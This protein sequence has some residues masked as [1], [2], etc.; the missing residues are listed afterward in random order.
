M[1]EEGWKAPHPGEVDTIRQF[2]DATLDRFAAFVQA[3]HR[4][5]GV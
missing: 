4:W 3:K 5:I 1:T 2:W